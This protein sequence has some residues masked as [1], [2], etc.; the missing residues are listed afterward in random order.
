MKLGE[1]ERWFLVC[2]AY[3][4]LRRQVYCKTNLQ[5]WQIKKDYGVLG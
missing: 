5:G 1:E 3:G 4:E 2:G